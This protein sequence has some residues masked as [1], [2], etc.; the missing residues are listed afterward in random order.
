MNNC[1]LVSITNISASG[2]SNLDCAF[3]N[4]KPCTGIT[5]SI[6]SNTLIEVTV[7]YKILDFI[8][9]MLIKV[10][11]FDSNGDLIIDGDCSPVLNLMCEGTQTMCGCELGSLTSGSYTIEVTL[12]ATGPRCRQTLIK[13]ETV[14]L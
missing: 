11:F 1:N 14:S 2:N 12:S 8:N 3:S 5:P 9:F 6:G 4:F 13:K 7:D 10:R